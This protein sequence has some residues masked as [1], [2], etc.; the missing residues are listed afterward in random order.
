[1]RSSIFAVIIK[2][3]R[4]IEIYK[5][6]TLVHSGLACDRKRI[7][8]FAEDTRIT[9]EIG[10]ETSVNQRLAIDFD[11]LENVSLALT[12]SFAI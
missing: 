12:V 4:I 11:C 10:I 1:M 3:H 9:S 8:Y 6:E 7:R 5:M 2:K